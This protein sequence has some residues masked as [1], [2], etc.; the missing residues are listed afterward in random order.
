M[1]SAFDVCSWWSNYSEKDMAID[2]Q[3]ISHVKVIQYPQTRLAPITVSKDMVVNAILTQVLGFCSMIYNIV[4]Y[5][6]LDYTIPNY[7]YFSHTANRLVIEV[8]T[9]RL[10]AC[11]F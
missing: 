6:H 8:P 5:I 7:S 11:S 2:K 3:N 9:I 10:P 4:N 1:A